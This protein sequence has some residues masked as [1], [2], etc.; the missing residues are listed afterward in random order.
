MMIFQEEVEKKKDKNVNIFSD[1]DEVFITIK[2]PWFTYIK[3]G[4]KTI[5]GRINKGLFNR[6]QPGTVVNFKNGFNTVK[7]KITS[8]Q[9]YPSFEDMLTKEILSTVLPNVNSVPEGVNVYRQYFTEQV[10]S[11]YGVVAIRFTKYF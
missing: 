6:I 11:E 10:E 4:K 8:K 1:I 7:V 5:E 3:D 9:E 2:E